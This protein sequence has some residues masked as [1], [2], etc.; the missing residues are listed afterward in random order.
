VDQ[1]TTEPTTNGVAHHQDE[2]NE[3]VRALESMIATRKARH[4]ELQ[5]QL[6]EITPELRRYQRALALIKGESPQAGRPST[7]GTKTHYGK[8]T[9]VSEE[10][11][12]QVM[13]AIR[14]LAETNDEFRQVDVRGVVDVTSGVSAMAF[15]ALRQRGIIRLA[16]QEGNNKF[17]RLTREALAANAAE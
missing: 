16:R 11:V 4:D 3:A 13:G 7:K 9:G 6:E 12:E 8:T 2:D 14:K 15:E 17:Y 1:L 10:R 5:A